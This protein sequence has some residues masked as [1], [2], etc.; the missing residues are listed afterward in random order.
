MR[1]GTLCCFPSRIRPI[2]IVAAAITDLLRKTT[3]LKMLLKDVMLIHRCSS[4]LQRKP[5]TNNNM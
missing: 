2:L 1:A 3:Q 4:L 5:T